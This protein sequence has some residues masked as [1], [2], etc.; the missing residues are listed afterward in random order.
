M[1]VFALREH[2][3]FDAPSMD[4]AYHLALAEAFARGEELQDGAFFRAPLYPLL[5]GALVRLFGG[6]LIAIRLVQCALGAVAAALTVRIAQRV[7]GSPLAG[8][9][10]GVLVAVS[11]ILVAFDGELLIPTLLVPLL[12]FALDRLTLLGERPTAIRVLVVGAAFGLTAIARPN[13]LLFMPPLFVWMV[14]RTRALIPPLALTVGTLLPILPVTVH[15]AL[16]GDT[17]LIATQGGV[18]LWIGNNP[19]SDG[20]AAIVPGTRDG[21][22]EG[23]YDSIALAGAEEGRPLKGSEVSAHYLRRTFS[24]WRAEPLKAARLMARKARLFFGARELSNNQDV[25]F[26]ASRT[27]PILAFSPARWPALLGLGVVG[28]VLAIRTRRRGAALL[29][30]FFAAYA[31][32][33]VLFFVT[34]R[35]RAPLIPVLAVFSG[36][37]LERIIAALRER[38]FARAAMLAAPATLIAL[39]SLL[40]SSRESQ[41]EALGFADLGRAEV[42]RNRPLSA[43]TYLERAH[44]L[45]P[46]NP[47]IAVD[48]AAELSRLANEHERALTILEGTVK[49]THGT[50]FGQDALGVQL[51]VM[52][53][54]GKVD[55]ALKQAERLIGAGRSDGR[56]R[57]VRSR[58]LAALGRGDEALRELQALAQ[59]EPTSFG[60]WLLA[61]RIAEGLGRFDEARTAFTQVAALARFA[62]PVVAD[63]ARAAL[64]RLAAR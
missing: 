8:A 63:E 6:D 29:V 5:L 36:L 13:V 2:P 19:A 41:S 30:L 12:L 55:A 39:L 32:S 49:R 24:W 40:A 59:D 18:N 57:M 3:R 23:Y 25:T 1:Y 58:A 38:S 31:A 47:Q 51:D 44:T 62:P 26:T 16:A 20:S 15:N 9:L 61:G 46:G 22:W 21:W 34:A 64:Q 14:W 42:A 54:A 43:L 35:F 7:T 11:W 33:I 53:N 10:A 27:L 28:A 56:V 37:T 50:P 45:S 60:P 52:I 17:T 48:F 4:A